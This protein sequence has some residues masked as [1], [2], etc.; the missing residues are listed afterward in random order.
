PGLAASREGIDWSAMS[1]VAFDQPDHGSAPSQ[2]RP[3]R[4]LGRRLAL[5]ILIAIGAFVIA[6]LATARWGDKRLWPPAPGSPT[7]EVFVA[8]HGY[9]AGIV[10]PRRAIA[11]VAE[12]QGLVAIGQMTARF[13]DFEWLEVGWGEE[14]FYRKVPTIDALTV[15]L[16]AR[17]LL[18]P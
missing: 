11:E 12:R 5:G 1:H 7:A 6:V 3:L 13:A 14:R 16:A 2:R 9:H 15:R 18:R 17:A 10:L 8:S 4:M